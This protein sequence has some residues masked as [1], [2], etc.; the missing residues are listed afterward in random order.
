MDT[1]T[2]QKA[3]DRICR[4]LRAQGRPCPSPYDPRS[5]GALRGPGR[6]KD[7]VG[8][9]FP[10]EEYRD[11]LEDGTPE[12]WVTMDPAW[13]IPTLGPESKWYPGG[14]SVEFL[15]AVMHLHDETLDPNCT[16]G[17]VLE[18]GLHKIAE[19]F[20]LSVAEVHGFEGWGKR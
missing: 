19:R 1:K 13:V 6:L 10:D 7:A 4:H 15:N 18:N 17:Y 9:L 16:P 20:G 14:L 12:Q 11:E 2:A 5:V 8:C 3:F